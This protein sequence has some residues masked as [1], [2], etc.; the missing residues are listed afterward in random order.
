MFRIQSCGQLKVT[1]IQLMS[2]QRHYKALISKTVG[3]LGKV[4]RGPASPLLI[5][6]KKEE[7]AEESKAS[8]ANKSKPP[9]PLTEV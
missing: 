7:M 8:R 3:D 5:L 4:P 9:A 1:D 6:G 2:L